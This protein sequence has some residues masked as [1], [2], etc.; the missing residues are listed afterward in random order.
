MLEIA[1][2]IPARGGSKGIKDKNLQVICN[3]PLIAWTIE[4]ALQ[5]EQITSVWVSSDSDDILQVSEEYGANIIRRPKELAKDSSTSESA[6]LHAVEYVESIAKHID[7]V[8]APQCTSPVREAIDFDNA[9]SKFITN[10]YDS[11]FS[12]TF[13]PDFN[14]WAP[15]S[16]GEM[17]SVNYD[18]KN[19]NRRQDKG[20][21]YLENGSFYIY[22]PDVIRQFNN[23]LGGKIGIHCMDFWKSFQIDEPEDVIFCENLIKAYI[24]NKRELN[25]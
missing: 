25:L 21:Q 9:I 4:Q 23:R 2:I 13:I 20:E 7:I 19:R 1:C 6:W 15:N 16:A 5:A 24:L 22:K 17:Q 3:K 10:N 11:L 14:I 12:A 8:V 18:F